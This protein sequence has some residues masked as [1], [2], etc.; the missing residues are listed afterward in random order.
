MSLEPEI[1]KSDSGESKYSN[2]DKDEKDHLAEYEPA[3]LNAMR[4]YK[5]ANKIKQIN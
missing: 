3:L 4:K 2:E 5:N 1:Y